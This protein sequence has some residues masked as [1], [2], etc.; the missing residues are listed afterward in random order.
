MNRAELRGKKLERECRK[1]NREKFKDNIYC[2]G[3]WCD[4]D[5]IY[6]CRHCM[7]FIENYGYSYDEVM[8][9]RKD[10][11]WFANGKKSFDDKGD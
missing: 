2:L 11:E 10:E 1:A 6:M 8:K 4:D 9:V 7:A 3:L 5:P